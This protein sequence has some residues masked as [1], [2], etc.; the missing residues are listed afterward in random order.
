MSASAQPTSRKK[1]YL[2]VLIKS[3]LVGSSFI[4]ELCSH[5]QSS[6]SVTIRDIFMPNSNRMGC[7]SVKTK[8]I[9][10]KLITSIANNNLSCRGR[11]PSANIIQ[12]NHNHFQ[13]KLS[14]LNNVISKKEFIEWVMSLNYDSFDIQIDDVT[15][16]IASNLN[17]N[18][19]NND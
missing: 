19:S 18:T 4:T 16:K 7:F 8:K 17:S 15:T 9:A 1:Y 3:E 10:D 5:I 13:I 2:S 11:K 14:N 6:T 12:I